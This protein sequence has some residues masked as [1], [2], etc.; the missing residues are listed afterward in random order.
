V[1]R[2]R[3]E[4]EV[5]G[6]DQ[7]RRITPAAEEP[8]RQSRGEEAETPGGRKGEELNQGLICEIREGQGP[9]CKG[10]ATF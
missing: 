9:Y 5:A 1:T 10:L 8:G 2:G 4:Q 6:G 7:G 3:G